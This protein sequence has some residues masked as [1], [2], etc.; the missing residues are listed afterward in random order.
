MSLFEHHLFPFLRSTSLSSLSSH[1]SRTPQ[2]R[3][4]AICAGN[5]QTRW[6]MTAIRTIR[7]SG[8]LLPV[9]VVH[10]GP[11]DMDADH[12]R[13]I[14]DM[15]NGYDVVVRDLAAVLDVQSSELNGWAVKPY[16]ALVSGFSEVLVMDADVVWM[17]KPDEVF[18]EEAWKSTGAV[19]YYD[20]RTLFPPTAA[21]LSFVLSL[22]PPHHRTSLTPFHLSNTF[23]TGRSAHHMESGV[24]ALSK[25]RPSVLYSL[26]A[27]C[28]MNGAQ[29][30]KEAYKHVW[31]DK[32]TWW[33]GFEATGWSGWYGYTRWP[34]VQV[35]NLARG[36]MDEMKV[37]IS[38]DFTPDP[39]KSS[40]RP[41]LRV[42][43]IQLGHLD[44]SGTH[45]L[46]FNGGPL[47]NKYHSDSR[48]A[49]PSHLAVETASTAWD[50]REENV[51]CLHLPEGTPWAVDDDGTWYNTS[52]VERVGQ[53]AALVRALSEEERGFFDRLATWW[54]EVME[55]DRP[56]N[57]VLG[58][59]H[60]SGDVTEGHKG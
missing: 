49:R 47:R 14:L 13:R 32:E 19:F 27:T 3:G 31:G 56:S 42:C 43:S 2:S 26:L 29:E 18:E 17:G 33:M 4:I 51:A 34:A 46:W 60:K 28:K 16:A 22:L 12:R 20:R 36:D 11:Q 40:K 9:E 57:S 15:G 25:S 39:S 8:S 38:E 59:E 58:E 24:L 44:P 35:G 45:L 53:S 21:G 23:L 37:V 10:A 48:V 5:K 6:A 50:L 30:R 55:L 41:L 52:A 54:S 7:E 1:F